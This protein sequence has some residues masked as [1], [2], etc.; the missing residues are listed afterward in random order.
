MISSK[1]VIYLCLALTVRSLSFGLNDAKNAFNGAQ[2]MRKVA[3]VSGALLF[4]AAVPQA[5]AG[6]M[7][8]GKKLFLVNCAACHPN[9]QN[10]IMP[11]KTLEKDAL[12]E[13]LAGGR[14]EESVIR[15][16]TNGKNA[17]PAFGGRLSDEAIEVIAS[18]IIATSE[19]GWD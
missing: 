10:V 15:Q 14:S 8:A 6:D 9:G 1:G 3:A 2:A 11:Q 7:A 13:Y 18:Y 5:S 19:S 12:D 4:S 16:V 17:M